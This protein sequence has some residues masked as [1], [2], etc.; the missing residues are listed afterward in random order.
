MIHLILC[1]KLSYYGHLITCYVVIFLTI[2]KEY[3]FIVI[4]L[5]GVLFLLVYPRDSFWVLCSL[6]YNSVVNCCIL[7]LYTDDVELHFSHSDLH[8]VE[9]CLQSDLDAV[10][11]WLNSSHVCLNVGKS[12]IMLIG[13]HQRV[14]D[15]TLHVSVGGNRL[16][17]VRYLGVIIDSVLIWS[18]HINNNIMV[19]RIRSRLAAIVCYGSLL[20]A[21]I[22]V[23]YSAFVMPL[24]ES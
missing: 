2:S 1:S 14:A 5:I 16:T 17:Q 6:P 21:V 19:S 12:N 24:T 3:C 22:Y 7:D 13:S 9:T 4:Y 8:V 20:P 10:A 23:L 18:L 15:N 11:T